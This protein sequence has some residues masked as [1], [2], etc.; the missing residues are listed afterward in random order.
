MSQCEHLGGYRR[1]EVDF[2]RGYIQVAAARLMVMI[3]RC[4]HLAA[5]WLSLL[6][7]R[8][9]CDFVGTF[10]SLYL[11]V[12]VL[13]ASLEIALQCTWLVLC[14]H[15]H[16]D[17]QK[18]RAAFA[19]LRCPPD[20]V[21]DDLLG[22]ARC[23]LVMDSTDVLRVLNSV[24]DSRCAPSGQRQRTG[25]AGMNLIPALPSFI[26][27]VLAVTLF[28][29]PNRCLALLSAFGSLAS[30]LELHLRFRSKK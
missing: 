22:I 27:L 24:L 13:P 16:R 21:R 29:A 19:H 17:A 6:L 5:I 12:A 2:W 4:L 11:V 30:L 18:R 1:R 7:L 8:S 10:A 14:I 3:R 9:L 20:L 23:L 15:L 26:L 28:L 25:R